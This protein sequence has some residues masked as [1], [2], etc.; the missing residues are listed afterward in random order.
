MACIGKFSYFI[1]SLIIFVVSVTAVYL[2]D[3]VRHTI[4]DYDENQLQ[5][6]LYSLR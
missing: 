1:Q 2:I 5:L 3:C 6:S 4:D